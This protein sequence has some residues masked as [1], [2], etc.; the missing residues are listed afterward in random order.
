MWTAR[1]ISGS[2]WTPKA[3]LACSPMATARCVSGAISAAARSGRPLLLRRAIVRCASRASSCSIS[4][5]TA[6]LDLVALRPPL[7]GVYERVPTPGGGGD[8]DGFRPFASHPQLAWA[9]ADLRFIDLDGDGR[10]DVLIVGDD[11][12]VWYP[13]LGKGGFGPPRLLPRPRDEELGPAIVFSNGR[14][15]S[16][17]PISAAT[18]C[19]IWCASR[20]VGS[21]TGRTSD[22]AGL[23]RRSRWGASP[24]LD[25][26]D[27]FD[28]KRVLFADIDGTGPSDVLYARTRRRALL[29]QP[30]GQRVVGAARR[31]ATCRSFRGERH[32]R[33]RPRKRHRLPGVVVG[34]TRRY[35]IRYVDLIGSVKPHLL[36]EADNQLGLT[37]RVCVTRRRRVSISPIARPGFTGRRSC[38]FRFTS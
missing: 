25:R 21:A 14:R 2:I 28:A 34:G 7:P 18:V 12:F 38:R 27:Q 10:D 6:G 9:D 22:M 30:G 16:R 26:P 20:T 15:R 4:T 3:S 19:A 29:V 37:T 8:W 24:I 23:A 35:R 32:R 11:T 5:V 13:S 17:S 31:R 33:R 36:V 1:A